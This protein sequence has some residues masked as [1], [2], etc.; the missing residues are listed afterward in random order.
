[1]KPRK[2]A[3]EKE[4]LAIEQSAVAKLNENLKWDEPGLKHTY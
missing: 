1:M 4:F 2:I 3:L